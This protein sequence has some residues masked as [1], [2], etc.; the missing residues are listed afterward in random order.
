MNL[1]GTHP[2][3]VG[4][5]STHCHEQSPLLLEAKCPE[6]HASALDKNDANVLISGGGIKRT[7]SQ[8][9][10]RIIF[11]A[12][13]TLCSML[14]VAIAFSTLTTRWPLTKTK[15]YH[16]HNSDTYPLLGAP[17]SQVNNIP[18]RKK[19]TWKPLGG[20]RYI[21]Y[22]P[23]DPLRP[24]MDLEES[25]D[26]S[27]HRRDRVKAA[28][29]HAY[30]SYAKYAFGM[31]ELK[32]VTGV[33]DNIWKGL[34]TTMVDALDTLW[35]MNLTD[36]FWQAR[37]Y[38]RD[39]SLDYSTKNVSVICFETT[40]RSLG[41]LLSAYA[42]SHDPVFLNQAL[43][44]GKRIIR[45][46]DNNHNPTGIPYGRVNL[47]TGET[48]N[49]HHEDFTPLSWVGTLQ[50]EFRWLDEYVQ[51]DETAIMRQKVE[52]VIA[53]LHSLH[54]PNGLY[55]TL[56]RNVNVSHAE[57]A[58][59]HLT[60]G[61]NGDS[62]YEYLLK[63]WIQGGK[64]ESMYR[65]MYDLAIQGLHDHLIEYSTPS[66]LLYF[67]DIIDGKKV[68]KLHHLTCFMGGLLSLGAYTDPRGFDSERARRDLKTAKALTYTCYQM[69]AQQPTGLSPEEVEFIPGHDFQ[70][71]GQTDVH[72]EGN[73][74][75][76][77]TRPEADTTSSQY[78]MRP[79]VVES[80]YHLFSITKDPIYR[81]WGWEIFQAIE[82]FT[83]TEFAFGEFPNVANVSATPNNKMESFFLAETLKYLYLLLDPDD[84][85]DILETHVFNT[86]AHPL[87]IFGK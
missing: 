28:M 55:S 73:Q 80:F 10:C 38:I 65:D 57:F 56:V 30:G 2:K 85:V 17:H 48:Y 58:N 74:S 72:P 13:I 37:D 66:G 42:W 51:S 7:D 4:E 8:P 53:I 1:R 29:Q 20:L 3:K 44:L 39:R 31:D 81:E 18:T 46:F 43:D 71:E 23:G 64:T 52:D 34:A 82:A 76:Y 68:H 35:L 67:V 16:T 14:V 33:G 19:H 79:E 70:L 15:P 47:M 86:E 12:A 77:G 21:E 25:D 69:Y 87:P 59:N 50:L 26:I 60:F 75:N 49:D 62:F 9:Y 27:Q 83:R 11:S 22:K 6:A 41:G 32:P 5:L 61:A 63:A 40:I 45:S 78:I 24:L 36:E 54:P 84:P